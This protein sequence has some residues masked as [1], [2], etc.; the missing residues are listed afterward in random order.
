MP[1][2]S[3]SLLRPADLVAL[4][5][6][7]YNLRLDASDPAHPQLVRRHAAGESLLVF[8][9]QPQSIAEQAYFE[10]ATSVPS[11]AQA[12]PG[13]GPPPSNPPLAPPPALPTTS[14]IILPPGSTGS[15]MSGA[16]RVVLR[17][18]ANIHAIPYTIEGLLDWSRLVTVLPEAAQVQPGD[19]SA[20]GTLPPIVEPTAL[21]TAIEMPYRLLLAPNVTPG[22]E[23]AWVHASS[24]VEHAGRAELWHTRL[25]R[26]TTA[27][28]PSTVEAS[29]TRPL[30]VRAVWSPDFVADGPLPVDEKQPFL[31]AMS[32]RDRDQIV[33]LNSGFSGY[34]LTNED[35]SSSTYVPQPVDADRLFLSTLG[36]WLTS[37]GTWKFPVSYQWGT[38]LPTLPPAVFTDPIARATAEDVVDV[39]LSGTQG[40][41]L[42]E[43]DHIATQGRDHYVRIVYEGFLYP[44]GHRAS[45]VKVTERK[46]HAPGGS[47]GNPSPS[48]VAYLRQR[49]YIIVRE[50]EKT[51]STA[52]FVHAG[53]EMPLRELIGLKIHVT[54]DIDQ[55]VMITSATS[56][57]RVN[58][59]QQPFMF[60]VVGIDPSGA[61]VDFLAPLIFMSLAETN[62]SAVVQ[63]WAG[64][65][66]RRRC[67]VRGRNIAYADPPAGDTTLKTQALYFTAETGNTTPPFVAP[68]FL[69]ILDSASVVV[70]ALAALT[71]QGSAVQIAY[72]AP[73]LQNGIDPHAGVFADLVGPPLPAPFS[74]DKSGG[75][76]R[77]NISLTALSGR[78]GLVSGKAD[79]AAAGVIN[80]KE[81]FGDPDAKLFGTIDLSSLIPLENLVADATQNAPEIRTRAIPNRKHPTQLVTHLTWSPNLQNFPPPS[82]GPQPSSPVTITWNAG[83]SASVMLLKVRLEEHLDGTPPVSEAHGSL[84]FFE[85]RMLGV[86]A[87]AIDKI[88][89]DSSNGAKS[90]VTLDLANQN[91]IRFEGPLSFIQTLANVLP[92]GLFGGSGPSIK[93]TP[94]ALSVSY[95]LGLPPITCGVFS[96][97]HIAIMAGLDLPYLDGKPAVEFAFAS[98]GRPFLVTVEIF[99]GG[100]FVHVVLD[101]DGIR[102]VEGAIEFG[103]NFSFDI[104]V[105]SGGVHAMAGIYFKLQGSS[106]DLTGF[107]DIGGEVSV[108]GIISISLDLNLS[109]S[110]QHSPSGDVIQGRATMSVSVHVLF[111]SASVS[112]SVEKSFSAGSGDP[113]IDQLVSASDW[114]LYAGAFA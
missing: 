35:L 105:A 16:S 50:R 10:T 95:T 83:G 106:S 1:D 88:K 18:A 103:G 59:G 42:I 47:D 70:P 66:L 54:P 99:G 57:F 97:E 26:R 73:Y 64:D 110:W 85:L 92:P 37:R 7:G 80:P 52:P 56:S 21:Q 61:L 65:N 40:L 89:F 51:Y 86:I 82:A 87:L 96:L 24:T 25:A 6:D 29:S 27:G 53:R 114:A 108:L 19:S 31:A 28:T 71:G 62:V 45:L 9:F 39:P 81:Y 113:K 12:P 15:R 98:R 84:T 63:D 3:C 111:F 23:P 101:A 60:P 94:T 5:V 49:M 4:E 13:T 44:F 41:D 30:P 55:P 72:Y 17:L 11:S 112:I 78:K 102:M 58:V 67:I 75:F 90:I 77:P 33:I 36:G 46:V 69:P 93:L 2:L 48:P 34:T 8:T 100:G 91:P 104:G 68:P 43:W 14:D 76:S 38:K 32:N 109:L 20:T 74:A 107:V 22:A 79:D